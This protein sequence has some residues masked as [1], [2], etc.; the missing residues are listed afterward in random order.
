MRSASSFSPMRSTLAG[1]VPDA[2]HDGLLGAFAEAMTERDAFVEHKTFTAPAARGFRNVLQIFQNA[3]LEV[4][5]LRKTQC[6]QQRARFLAANAA[7][8]EHRDPL[9]P[10]R[11]KLARGEILELTEGRDA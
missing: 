2:F 7:G 5:D 9:V 1:C 6:E 10:G 8:A 3:A 11:I 4:I